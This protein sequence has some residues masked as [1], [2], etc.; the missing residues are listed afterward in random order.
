MRP[1][2]TDLMIGEF[3]VSPWYF[4]LWHVAADAVLAPYFTST[5]LNL[6]P[7]MASLAL[8]IVRGIC[9]IHLRVRV[10]AA[11][12]A[13]PAI[14]CVVTFAVDQAIGLE[15]HIHHS[16]Y[17]RTGNVVPRPVALATEAGCLLARELAQFGH[18]GPFRVANLH[19]PQMICGGPMAA[20]ALHAGTQRRESQS[21]LI[22]RISGMAPEAPKTFVR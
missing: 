19:R 17:P 2:N 1:R 10:V 21:F 14:V 13:N 20:L 9:P 15:T 6:A 4:D 16:G 22:D 7:T 8:C 18:S 3:K 11:R 5:R 12:A